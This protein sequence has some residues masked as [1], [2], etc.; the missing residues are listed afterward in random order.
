AR[1]KGH[2]PGNSLEVFSVLVAMYRGCY[3]FYNWNIF[4]PFVRGCHE[5]EAEVG[6]LGYFLHRR[7]GDDQ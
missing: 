6:I 2:S 3:N 4:D 1:K 5:L 7:R